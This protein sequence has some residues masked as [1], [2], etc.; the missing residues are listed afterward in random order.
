MTLINPI[1]SEWNWVGLELTI[2]MMYHTWVYVT[3]KAL[4]KFSVV[5]WYRVIIVSALSLSLRDKERFRDWESL[6]IM[7]MYMSEF[8]KFKIS[9]LKLQ[10]IMTLW[11]FETMS[12]LMKHPVYLH[13]M[14][15][16]DINNSH[17]NCTDAQ[18]FRIWILT[19]LTCSLFIDL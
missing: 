15:S 5:V 9:D 3:S 11:R 4:K 10:K 13:Q 18:P 7:K 19:I 14:L 6:T 17:Y 2:P 16:K 1:F 8:S 12:L